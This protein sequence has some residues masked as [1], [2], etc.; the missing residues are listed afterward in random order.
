MGLDG[1]N[2]DVTEEVE[3]GGDGTEAEALKKLEFVLIGGEAC[4]PMLT[5]DAGRTCSLCPLQSLQC[6]SRIC[7]S[8]IKVF[9]EMDI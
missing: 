3:E 6:S 9:H 4:L 2:D 8:A 1:A 7:E 5:V